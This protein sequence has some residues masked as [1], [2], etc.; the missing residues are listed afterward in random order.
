MKGKIRKYLLDFARKNNLESKE[1][2]V[3]NILIIK[4]SFSGNGE[5]KNCCSS[6]SYGY[7]W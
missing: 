1:D 6:E 4:T 5:Q 3:G 2:E 7:G